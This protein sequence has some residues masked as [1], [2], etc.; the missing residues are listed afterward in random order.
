MNGKYVLTS[1]PWPRVSADLVSQFDVNKVATQIEQHGWK[2][3]S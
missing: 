2:F 1:F 3:D